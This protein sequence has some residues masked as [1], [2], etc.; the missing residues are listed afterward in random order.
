[1]NILDIPPIQFQYY[2]PKTNRTIVLEGTFYYDTPNV[3]KDGNRSSVNTTEKPDDEDSSA[4]ILYIAAVILVWGFSV[5]L[6]LLFLNRKGAS[7]EA[8]SEYKKYIQGLPKAQKD[9]KKDLVQRMRLMWPGNYI[10]SRH[11]SVDIEQGSDLSSDSEDSQYHRSVS[12][13]NLHHDDPDDEIFHL[14]ESTTQSITKNPSF[15]HINRP[16][17]NGESK[18]IEHHSP[19]TRTIPAITITA[20]PDKHIGDKAEKQEVRFPAIKSCLTE[21]LL[22]SS[23]NSTPDFSGH[24][25]RKN[26]GSPRLK[27]KL[28]FRKISDASDAASSICDDPV[29]AAYRDSKEYMARTRGRRGNV[30]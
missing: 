9:A 10:A 8:D 27:L 13:Y 14:P 25:H 2:D 12:Q 21:S 20:A 19:R 22:P 29:L 16:L 7:K 18:S 5:F 28:P 26:A 11:E 15:E 6:V 4:Q 30:F 1:M 24:K 23:T 17:T 3:T